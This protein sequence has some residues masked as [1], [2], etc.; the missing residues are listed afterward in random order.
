MMRIRTALAKPCCC[1]EY[2]V[3]LCICDSKIPH[4]LRVLFAEISEDGDATDRLPPRTIAE[5]LPTG[6]LPTLTSTD[7]HRNDA[8]QHTITMSRSFA[9]S[10]TLALL[11]TVQLLLLLLAPVQA[12]SS[13]SSSEATEAGRCSGQESRN[14]RL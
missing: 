6:P 3:H 10:W 14:H 4:L 13:S 7:G 9:F 8:K 12:S 2:F 5:P 11:L 1:G